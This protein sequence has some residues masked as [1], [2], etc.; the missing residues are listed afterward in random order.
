MKT[1]IS[2]IL[3]IILSIVTNAQ[4]GTVKSFTKISQPNFPVV[5]ANGD[6]LGSCIT[7]IGDLDKDGV[8]DLAIGAHDGQSNGVLYIA[9]LN[10]NG[11]VKSVTNIKKGA[12]GLP[13]NMSQSMIDFATSI[14]T[15]GDLD[16]DG[17]V[18]LIVGNPYIAFGSDK[19]FVF[20]L[21]MNSN[22]TVKT[23]KI[24]GEGLNGFS[25][26]LSNTRFGYS[27]AGIGDL[28][29]DGIKD[30]AVGGDKSDNYRGAVWILLLNID[31]TVK[32][33]Y[34]LDFTNTILS[35]YMILSKVQGC[36][37]G[38]AVTSLGDID[39]DGN[40]DIGVSSCGYRTTK[41]NGSAAI[42]FLNANGTIKNIKQIHQGI[43]NF[44]DTLINHWDSL[45]PNISTL[46]G[47][48]LKNIGDING[49]NTND[50][51]IGAPHFGE[52]NCYMC[53]A[54]GIFMLDTT[55]NIK[56]YQRISDSLGNFNG[57]L[58]SGDGFGFS[59]SGIGDSNG[60]K[61]NDI[62]VGAKRDDGGGMD[63]GA[64]YILRLN[65]VPDNTSVNEISTLSNINIFPNPAKSQ[66]TIEL[67]NA[68]YS[69]LIWQLMDIQGKTLK[70]GK[71]NTTDK[72]LS[73]SIYD[74]DN[75][76]YLIRL[77]NS[78]ES[79]TKKLVITK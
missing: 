35:N 74:L 65:G 76:I 20:I 21:F 1:F 29:H 51:V 37:F 18:D 41:G 24:I 69:D 16:N 34:K 42:L 72:K 3:V 48:S 36:A 46:F 25:D 44:N 54:I 6:N 8:K 59:V 49:D 75:G 17:N 66:I 56:A 57:H 19:G 39:K 78:N 4:N 60:D 2:L 12:S 14:D 47:Y 7:S 23:Y 26:N 64:V 15:I 33:K 79:F 77:K 55:G 9:F 38:S 43:P 28:N 13:S 31:G 62:I 70:E 61:I 45:N 58:L 52:S 68:N 5:L 11:T 10:N 30:I 53:G 32:N 71:F 73:I 67:G 50:I 63:R 40:I 27:V 22:G